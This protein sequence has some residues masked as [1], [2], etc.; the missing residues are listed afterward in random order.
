[1]TPDPSLLNSEK[2]RREHLP[3][4]D[5]I[6]ATRRDFLTK[7]GMGF[8]ALSLSSIFGMNLNEAHAA[9]GSSSPLS[10][11]RAP[12]KSK[13]KAVI[14]IFASGGPSQVETWEP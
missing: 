1:M 7:T 3:S 6:I 5:D 11:K 9:S 8:G 2:Y 14:H 4:L 13:A 12:L 10:P